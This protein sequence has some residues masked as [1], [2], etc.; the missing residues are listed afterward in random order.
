MSSPSPIAAIT[1]INARNRF[2]VT[3]HK[4]LGHYKPGQYKTP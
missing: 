4:T 3:C 2:G 1:A